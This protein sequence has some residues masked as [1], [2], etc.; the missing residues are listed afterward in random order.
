MKATKVTLIIALFILFQ[1][2]GFSQFYKRFDFEIGVNRSKVFN[3]SEMFPTLSEDEVGFRYSPESSEAPVYTN[4][5]SMSLGFKIANR[6]VIRI[7]RSHNTVG[8]IITGTFYPYG[9]FCGMGISPQTLR[10]APN[11]IKSKS[12]GVKYELHTPVH[13][14]SLLIG[15]GFE[16]QWNSFEDTFVYSQGILFDNYAIHSSVGFQVPLFSLIHLHAKAFMTRSLAN[17]TNEGFAP[18][19]SE[20]IPL[21]IGI[22][23]GLRFKFD[24]L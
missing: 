7:R 1:T 23:L 21:Q 18:L 10:N 5:F 22:E 11:V 15:L 17:N 16:K 20:Y 14:G 9:G 24:S 13:G 6:H 19:N 3:V 2:S 4:N 12:M 8:G